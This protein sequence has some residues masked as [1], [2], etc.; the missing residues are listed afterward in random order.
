MWRLFPRRI[1]AKSSLTD[2]LYVGSLPRKIFK[3]FRTKWRWSWT[4]RGNKTSNTHGIQACLHQTP[5]KRHPEG[6]LALVIFFSRANSLEGS[7]MN[8]GCRWP[9][10]SAS[11][12]LEKFI[13]SLVRKC[14]FRREHGILNYHEVIWH[15]CWDQPSE[16]RPSGRHLWLDKLKLKLKFACIDDEAISLS[17]TSCFIFSVLE[18][19]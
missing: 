1:R 17:F 13:S 12:V 11:Q 16:F 14:F 2:R 19:C 10:S 6:K 9:L 8:Y 3:I 18:V 5:A 15:E 7:E 4:I